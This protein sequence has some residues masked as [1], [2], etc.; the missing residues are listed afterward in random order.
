[1]IKVVYFT[2][3]GASL[4]R[5]RPLKAGCNDAHKDTVFGASLSTRR[6]WCAPDESREGC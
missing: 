4:Y 3:R 6:Q 2:I 5:G 1:M